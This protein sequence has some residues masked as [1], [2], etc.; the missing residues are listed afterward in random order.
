MP[1]QQSEGGMVELTGHGVGQFCGGAGR[2][3]FSLGIDRRQQKFVNQPGVVEALEIKPTVRNDL[4]QHCAELRSGAGAEVRQG[5]GCSLDVIDHVPKNRPLSL[6]R[7]ADVGAKIELNNS[8]LQR[9][10]LW[11]GPASHA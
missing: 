2:D 11:L 9:S 6:E 8:S 5:V 1:P 4:D 3:Q 7:S 10:Q